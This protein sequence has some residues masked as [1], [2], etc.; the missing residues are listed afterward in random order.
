MEIGSHVDAQMNLPYNIAV[1][2]HRIKVGPDW[3]AR[4]TIDNPKIREF[5]KKVSYETNPRCEEARHQDLVV[6]GRPYISR[7]PAYAEVSARGTSFTQEV[8]YAKWL[9]MDVEEFR[10]GDEGLADKFRANASKVLKGDK[11]EKAI[12][13]IYGLEKIDDIT[14]LIP[15]LTA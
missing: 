2:A 15:L 7:R 6:E 9:S 13:A 3:Q 1:A 11:L 8:E 14:R 5:M 10:V 12:E 4:S